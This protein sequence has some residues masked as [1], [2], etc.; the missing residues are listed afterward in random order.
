MAVKTIVIR[1]SVD[2]LFDSFH[3]DPTTW[4]GNGANN[5]M[6][7]ANTGMGD[8]KKDSHRDSD[9]ATSESR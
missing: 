5:T 4:N 8:K 1:N 2:G 3:I 6:T 7:E 9:R